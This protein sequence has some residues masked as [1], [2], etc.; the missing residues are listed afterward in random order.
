MGLG[1]RLL[2]EPCRATFIRTRPRQPISS[3]KHSQVSFKL[4]DADRRCGG[5]HVGRSQVHPWVL[6]GSGRDG[7]SVNHMLLL[8]HSC[9]RFWYGTKRGKPGTDN[10]AAPFG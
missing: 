5:P 8:A 7:I 2:G 6:S 4:T 3:K 9:V 1:S 10:S